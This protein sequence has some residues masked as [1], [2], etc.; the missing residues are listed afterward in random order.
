MFITHLALIETTFDPIDSRLCN[1]ASLNLNFI[2]E[3]SS[4]LLLRKD[5]QIDPLLENDKIHPLHG[6]FIA[7][8]PH[9]SGGEKSFSNKK[10]HQCIALWLI[11]PYL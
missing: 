5:S 6:T 1:S 7:S 3:F 9:P 11:G 4:S 10:C 8:S 2:F